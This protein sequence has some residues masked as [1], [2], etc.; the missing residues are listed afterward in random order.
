L[1]SVTL[2]QLG[3]YSIAEKIGEGGMGAVYR[4]IDTRLNRVVALKVLP[5]D[6]TSNAE[7]RRRFVQEAQSASALN[8]PNIVNI[9]AID[10][11]EGVDFIAMEYVDGQALDRVIA[12]A[13]LSV[14]RAL[15]YAIQIAG[16]LAAAHRAGIVH[17]DIKPANILLSSTG[18]IK[19]L[20]F[21]LAK[22]T[23]AEPRGAGLHAD[24]HAAHGV[25]H[26]RRHRR[27]HVARTGGRTACRRADGH[28]LVRRDVV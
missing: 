22:L 8:H 5:A 25:G 4:A 6:A 27:L 3:H 9:Y 20:D 21:G 23:H 2:H 16:A 28:L 26:H 13:P 1:G 17:R 15:D 14:A 11:A 7:R 10:N 18:N 19:V 12:D 24:R